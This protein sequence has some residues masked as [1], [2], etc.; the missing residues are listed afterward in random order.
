MDNNELLIISAYEKLRKE[1]SEQEITKIDQIWEEFLQKVNKWPKQKEEI[2]SICF[3]TDM[4]K[5]A[6]ISLGGKIARQ[7]FEQFLT[8]ISNVNPRNE[9]QS[10]ASVYTQDLNKFYR[11]I[12]EHSIEGI[13]S[14]VI[15]YSRLSSN[16]ILEKLSY[17]DVLFSVLQDK[18]LH[19]PD[20]VQNKR[21]IALT[22]RLFN[23]IF[24]KSFTTIVKEDNL[25]DVALKLGIAP[26][27][28]YVTKQMYIR[29]A[30]EDCLNKHYP[31][32]KSQYVRAAT[33]WWM[34]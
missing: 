1:I 23:S 19:Y 34:K 25:K 33:A 6:G 9:Y 7:N 32:E 27:S 20:Y 31:E 26:K 4:E 29:K 28:S 8:D 3:S 14:L 21:P 30:V 18:M 24:Q 11:D 12:E 10:V 17:I 22:A 2:L 13:I 15:M 16:V 5:I